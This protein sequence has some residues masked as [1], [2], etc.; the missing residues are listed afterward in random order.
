MSCHELYGKKFVCTGSRLYSEVGDEPS[1]SGPSPSGRDIIFKHILLILLRL[2]STDLGAA[3]IQSII[4]P[5]TTELL[6][7]IP[8]SNRLLCSGAQWSG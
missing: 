7:V 6:V 8:G 1:H 2:M 5:F 3:H 4:N